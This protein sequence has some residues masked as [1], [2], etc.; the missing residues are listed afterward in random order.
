MWP[1]LKMPLDSTSIIE[2]R[3]RYNA[4]YYPK[5]AKTALQG[6][7]TSPMIRDKL[8]VV[9]CRLR[10]FGTFW[11]QFEASE[12]TFIQLIIKFDTTTF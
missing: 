9:K 1:D 11:D 6:A 12:R 2:L 10:C 4:L 5:A 7:Q 8:E 3:M